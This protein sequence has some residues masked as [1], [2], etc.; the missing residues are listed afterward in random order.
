ML[1][2]SVPS[3][4]TGVPSRAARPPDARQTHDF[5]GGRQPFLFARGLAA[6]GGRCRCDGGGHAEEDEAC[7]EDWVCGEGE[8]GCRW[9]CRSGQRLHQHGSLGSAGQVLRL[10]CPAWGSL[11]ERG[12]RGVE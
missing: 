4:A 3:P 10:P 5:V 6:G 1:T 9:G 8:G 7:Q 11:R 2:F 12:G